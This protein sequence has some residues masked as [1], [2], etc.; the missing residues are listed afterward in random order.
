MYAL[1]NMSARALE[2][3][4]KAEEVIKMY[5]WTIKHRLY[6]ATEQQISRREENWTHRSL[7]QI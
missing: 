7:V 6:S 3:K 4:R 2:A 5:L 1:E